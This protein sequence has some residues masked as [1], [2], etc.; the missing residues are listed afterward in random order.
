MTESNNS[1]NNKSVVLV[2]GTLYTIET[3]PGNENR[4]EIHSG[5]GGDYLVDTHEPLCII[6][7]LIIGIFLIVT[8]V[9]GT[10]ISLSF[11]WVGL[12]ALFGYC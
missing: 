10:V 4:Y 12:R 6:W 5:I 2:G 8:G 1:D 7:K 11:V 3:G 9:F